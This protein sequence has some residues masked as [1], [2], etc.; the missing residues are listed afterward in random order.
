MRVGSVLTAQ[1]LSSADDQPHIPASGRSAAARPAGSSAAYCTGGPVLQACHGSGA[2]PASSHAGGMGGSTRRDL[3]LVLDS[4]SVNAPKGPSEYD[5][6]AR[7]VKSGGNEECVQHL[8]SGHK[9]RTTSILLLFCSCC[10]LTSRKRP[11]LACGA[12]VQRNMQ[13]LPANLLPSPNT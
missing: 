11:S 8:L 1:V 6:P 7:G 2:P 4:P 13:T 10:C 3:F 9:I 5:G 12:R